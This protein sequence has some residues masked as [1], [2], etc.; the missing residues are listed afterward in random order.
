MSALACVIYLGSRKV[1]DK[2][3]SIPLI[4]IGMSI[5]WFGWFGFTAGNAFAMNDIAVVTFLNTRTER[6]GRRGS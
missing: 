1:R 6:C 2:P 3:H 5:L 4:A